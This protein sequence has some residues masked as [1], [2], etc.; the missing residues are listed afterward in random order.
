VFLW[1]SKGIYVT[2]LG[3]LRWS[4]GGGYSARLVVGRTG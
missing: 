4:P 1:V 2:R 3:I